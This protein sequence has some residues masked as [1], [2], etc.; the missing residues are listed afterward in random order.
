MPFLAKKGFVLLGH[1]HDRNSMPILL[2]EVEDVHVELPI[3]QLM[4]EYLQHPAAAGNEISA[5]W[6]LEIGQM[7]F[8]DVGFF[9]P[10]AK[11]H[12]NIELY[13]GY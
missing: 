10:N 11:R 3:Q 13:K 2:K 5:C 8:L 1:N 12:A 6:F 4:G 9:K 7:A